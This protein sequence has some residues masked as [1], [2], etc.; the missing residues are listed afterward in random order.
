M[1]DS[2]RH[3]RARRLAAGAAVVVGALLAGCAQFPDEHHGAWK[4]QP[5][6]QPQA[7][8]QP[9]I[10]G[11]AQPPPSGPPQQ[12]GQ[13]QP[14]NGC[15]DPDRSVVATCLDPVGAI[16]VLPDGQ[17]ALVGEKATGR[18]LRVRKGSDPV[19]I[20]RIPVDP[21]GG[22]GL[23]GL[24]LS[25]SYQEDELFYA[26]ATTSG[27]NQVVRVA[28]GDRPKPILS[29]IPKGASGNSGALLTD[30]KGALLVATGN[31]GSPANAGN[32][33]SL[34]GKVL[35]IDG[36][37]KPAPD[38]PNR[39]S[40]V[41]SSGLAAPGGLCG[42]PDGSSLWVT[43]Q[44][45]ERDTLYRVRPGEPLGTPA[46]TWPDRPGVGGCVA[47]QAVVVAALT[48]ASALFTMHPGPDGAFT[49]Q[50]SKVLENTYG[51]FS[52]AAQS[53]DG[54]VWLGTANKAG[55]R[56]VPSDDRVIRIEPPSGGT[57][58]KD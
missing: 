23:T 13:R 27:G 2:S 31:G 25:P 52:A 32:P 29:G 12:P 43:D 51:R 49:G 37:G 42:S 8:P 35:R 18:V 19:E 9:S 17:S 7:G 47:S 53:Q 11:E 22:G 36:F 21:S 10:E 20:A 16:A 1:P 56:P 24:A 55:G 45:G 54:L 3:R 15:Q 40:P 44:G 4:D 46:W 50:P 33:G 14:P 26:F 48:N 41:V 6:L 30:P 5:S 39:G 34:G 57:A 58:G 38:N 28:P